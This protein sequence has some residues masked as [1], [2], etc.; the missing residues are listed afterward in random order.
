[1]AFS[2]RPTRAQLRTQVRYGLMDSAG[3]WWSDTA[4]NGWLDEWV[5]CLQRELELEWGTATL[6]STQTTGTYTYTDIAD[7]MLRPGAVYWNNQ[8]LTPRN[9]EEMFSLRESWRA[10][11][12]TRPGVIIPLDHER[13]EL[14]PPPGTS[15]YLYFDYPRFSTFASDTATVPM[16]SWVR[17]SA[18]PYVQW[19]SYLVDGP[20]NDRNK[21]LVYKTQFTRSLNR[22]KS[23]RAH[24][25]PA[26]PPVLRPGGIYVAD[27]LL[28]RRRAPEEAVPPVA[29]HYHQ[30]ETPTGTI[31]GTNTAFTL[32]YPPSPTASLELEV[33]GLTY[34][35]GTHY[36]LSSNT[37]SYGT[38][39]TPTSGQIHYAR[40]RRV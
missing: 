20:L 8:R 13:F 21:A 16:P 15:G 23:L 17:Y 11:D 40:Y 30:E 27:I 18:T 1:M 37:I 35:Q 2:D 25:A 6:L 3:S 26:A 36:T 14:W 28:A 7:D 32:S 24:F 5:T 9:P 34:V 38:A 10:T 4:V 12:E 39:Y 33:N 31:N 19:R 29:F 22:L